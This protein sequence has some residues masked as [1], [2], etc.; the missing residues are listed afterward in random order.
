MGVFKRI[1]KNK[2]GEG[3]IDVVILVLIAMMV[4]ALAVKVYPVF[5]M[6]DS[7][8]TL[9]NQLIREAQIQGKIEIGYSDMAESI[10]VNV[11]T[12]TWEADTIEDNKVQ[13]DEPITVTLTAVTDIG[14]FGEFGSFP[15]T[16]TSKAIGKSEVYWK[17]D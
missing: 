3:Y 15:I 13:L 6:K 16:V 5:I 8:N 14:L 17:L 12:I 1:I 9:A 10:G 2:K 4:I 7:L 11:E